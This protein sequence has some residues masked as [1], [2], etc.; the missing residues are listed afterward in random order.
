MVLKKNIS[1]YVG[2]GIF[3]CMVVWFS[4]GILQMKGQQMEKTVRNGSRLLVAK[5]KYTFSFPFA[6][7]PLMT[8]GTIEHGTLIAFHYPKVYDLPTNKK[9][10]LISRCVGQ[11][12]DTIVIKNKNLFVDGDRVEEP[13]TIQKKYRMFC[14]KGDFDEDFY[15][16][17]NITQGGQVNDAGLFDFPLTKDQVDRLEN[18]ERVSGLRLLKKKTKLDQAIFPV[19]PFYSFSIDDYGPV[20]VPQKGWTVPINIRNIDLYKQIIEHYEGNQLEVRKGK[21]FINGEEA[22]SYTFKSNYYFVLD[23]NRDY[24]ND[25]R[26][27]GFLPANHVMGSVLDL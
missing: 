12:G 4:F 26:S 7:E 23:D 3:L 14:K 24:A 10:I 16:D 18:D 19:S 9:P 11:P 1:L 17:Y 13:N 6:T 15:R 27:W 5:Y 8:Y 25:S 21:V 20:K 22:F 2:V